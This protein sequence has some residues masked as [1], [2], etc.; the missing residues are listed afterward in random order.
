MFLI[1]PITCIKYIPLLL[2]VELLSCN[3]QVHYPDGGFDYPSNINSRD[4]DL[5]F[6]PIRNIESARDAFWDSY[7]YCYYRPF[8]EPNLSIAPQTKETFRLTYSNA[9]GAITII[10][11]TEDSIIV[12]EGYTAALYDEDT[13]S[14][15]TIEKFHLSLLQSKFPIDTATM[16]APKKHYFDSLLKLYPQLLDPSYYHTLY[17]K[18]I[19]RNNE[20]FDCTITRSRITKKDYDSLISQINLSGFWSAPYKI[21]CKDPPMDGDGFCLEANTKKKYK[22]TF[23][24]GCPDDTTKLTK[25]CQRL[26]ALAHMDKKINLV[27]SG[28]VDTINIDYVEA[29]ALKEIKPPKNRKAK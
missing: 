17:A 1:K 9:F 5:Y 27:W 10:R 4:S 23:V 8:E 22:V 25:V 24:Y 18:T 3:S 19:K 7:A 2:A 16:N 14:L 20:K 11:L 6:Y 13:S 26:V 28:A 29:P 12:K 15:N 21:E